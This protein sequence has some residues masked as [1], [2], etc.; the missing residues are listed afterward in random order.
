V[1]TGV[2]TTFFSTMG[3]PIVRGRAFDRGE[4][5]G[6]SPV[7]ILSE[8]A[9]SNLFGT[10]DPLGASV[11]ITRQTGSVTATI[12]GV[13]RDV[14]SFGA[15]QS[16]GLQPPDIYLPR[17]RDEKED[18]VIVARASGDPHSLVRPVAA[19]AR[20]SPA[21]R[22]LRAYVLGD[23][24]SFVPPEAPLVFRIIGAFGLVA[25][26]LAATGIFGVVSQSVAQRTTEFG[27]RMAVGASRAQVLRMVLV[28]EGKLIAA[29]I[30]AGAIGT[31][32]VGQRAFGELITIAGTDPRMW[33]AV[34]GLCAAFAGTAALMATY[35]IVRMD[36]WGVLRNG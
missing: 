13:C 8:G 11:T 34:I 1:L 16:S 23:N 24:A 21:A 20:P 6:T 2:D 27:V 14:M 26:L 7:A 18:V 32:A 12:V 5:P 31:V 22:L 28:R 33:A 19:A 29:A 3:L 10:A 4:A 30:A 25:L 35:R 15:I 17:Q 9:A 36:P